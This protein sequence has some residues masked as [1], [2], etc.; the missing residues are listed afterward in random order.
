VNSGESGW[1]P[2]HRNS[3]VELVKERDKLLIERQL[4]KARQTKSHQI[5]AETSFPGLDNPGTGQAWGH[6][7]PISS[8]HCGILKDG[9]TQASHILFDYYCGKATDHV[10]KVKY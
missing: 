9:F 7:I 1:E 6:L 3:L 10:S 5:A 8:H 2:E 4:E